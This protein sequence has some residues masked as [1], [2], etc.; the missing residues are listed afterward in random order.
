VKL[1]GW[2]RFDKIFAK[3]QL[4]VKFASVDDMSRLDAAFIYLF[5][6]NYFSLFG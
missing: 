3:L 6:I 4:F 1:L 5:W 2:Y